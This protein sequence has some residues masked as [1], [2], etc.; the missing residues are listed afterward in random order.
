MKL[1]IAKVNLFMLLCFFFAAAYWYLI[2]SGLGLG[3]NTIPLS[4]V[5]DASKGYVVNDSIIIEVEM[6][7]V[8]VTNIVSA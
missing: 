7:T 2:P 5:K 8:S 3:V 1:G 6:L 4:D